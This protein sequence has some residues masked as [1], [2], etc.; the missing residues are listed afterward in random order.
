MEW[1]MKPSSKIWLV[2]LIAIVTLW[3]AVGEAGSPGRIFGVRPF[4]HPRPGALPAVRSPNGVFIENGFNTRFLNR[5][6]FTGAFGGGTTLPYGW[7]WTTPVYGPGPYEG[8]GQY[9]YPV[10][11]PAFYGPPPANPVCNE[12]RIIDLAPVKREANLPR[13]IYGTPSLC[14]D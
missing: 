13:V 11:V 6:F 8:N 4:L 5:R 7:D 9:P 1:D 3:P 10:P 12:P 2:G 14:T